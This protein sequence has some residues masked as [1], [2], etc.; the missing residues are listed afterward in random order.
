MFRRRQG[1]RTMTSHGVPSKTDTLHPIRITASVSQKTSGR[2]F[3][4]PHPFTLS[5]LLIKFKIVQ[6]VQVCLHHHVRILLNHSLF[7]SSFQLT[8]VAKMMSIL[9]ALFLFICIYRCMYLLHKQVHT[10]HIVLQ[11]AFLL[12][13]RSCVLVHID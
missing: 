13:N 3:S 12:S 7:H 4:L 6:K 11:I 8:T 5:L 9:P 10:M 1:A 2:S